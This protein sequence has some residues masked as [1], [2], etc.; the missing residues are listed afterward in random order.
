MDRALQ[1]F[2]RIWVAIAV[3][4][5]IIAIAG[6]F[7]GAHG[8]W[9]GWAKVSEIYSPFNLTNYV[10]ELVLVSPAIGAYWWLERRKKRKRV[11]TQRRQ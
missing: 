5:N 10:V 8:F 2:I 11:A 6:F 9:A 4:V 7:I 3:A 1:W